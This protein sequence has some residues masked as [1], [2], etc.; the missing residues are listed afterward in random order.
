MHRTKTQQVIRFFVSIVT[1]I[2]MLIS[3]A[4]KMANVL[5][6]DPPA[7]HLKAIAVK[8]QVEMF[9]FT[10]NSSLQLTVV[11][12]ENTILFDQSVVMDD[13]GYAEQVFSDF[14]LVPGMTI[15]ASEAGNPTNTKVLELA[16]LTLGSVNLETNTIAGIA[17]INTEFDVYGGMKTRWSWS[18]PHRM[19]RGCGRPVL[20]HYHPE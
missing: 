19:E 1:I 12:G 15:T 18:P 6:E 8:N 4:A 11:D 14:G 7:P 2:S 20:P 13:H 5:A 9:D 16:D 10:A 3:P 17:P